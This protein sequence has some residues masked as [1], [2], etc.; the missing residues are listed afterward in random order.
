VRTGKTF[1]NL[2]YLL[3]KTPW[4][5]QVTPPEVVELIESEVL[6]PGR[7][8]D[9]GCGTGTNAV[10]LARHGWNVVGVDFSALAIRRAVR[11]ARR[12]GVACT[13]Y[14]ADVTD[15][16]FLHQ[17]FD[18]G[19]DIG[20]LHSVPRERRPFYAA[21]V[22]RLIRPGGLLMLYAF[23]PKENEEHASGRGLAPGEVRALLGPAFEVQ[24]QSGGED[25]SGPRSVWYWLRR[26]DIG[27]R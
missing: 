10:Y 18:L 1:F 15:L 24:R 7:A 8:L 13:F 11:R 3:G 14:Q 17:P 6:T 22:A 16:S 26:K 23:A 21:H 4:D 19:L 27:M 2:K 9:L 12:A 20:C 5:T 25:P